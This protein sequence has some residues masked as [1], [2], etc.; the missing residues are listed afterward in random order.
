MKAKRIAL[1]TGIA[2]VLLLLL[3]I[4]LFNNLIVFNLISCRPPLVI[5]K[6]DI[7]HPGLL[8]DPVITEV[9]YVQSVGVISEPD[10][11]IFEQGMWD[12]PVA[13]RNLDVVCGINKEDA[14]RAEGMKLYLF[15]HEADYILNINDAVLTLSSEVHA[16]HEY[17]EF[18]SRFPDDMQAG[19]Y[20]FV[21]V[22]S[23]K[24]IDSAFEYEIVDK[25][26]KSECLTISAYKPVIY[27]YPEE[28]T[29]CLVSLDLDG[30]ITCSYPHYDEDYGWSVTAEPD[31]TLTDTATGREYDY[32]FWEGEISGFDGFDNAIC[33]RGCDTARFLEEY[34]DA[35]GL[36]YSEIDDFIS[37]WLPRMESNEYNLISFP[38]QEYE[39]EVT[40]NVS[41]EPDNVIRVYMVYT[42]LDE[43]VE[44]PEENQLQWPTGADRTGFTVVEWG[45]SVV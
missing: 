31:G 11:E 40:L 28:T 34:L 1:I 39:E 32:L 25:D 19:T 44:I 9:E 13:S 38:T 16:E 30:T 23:D 35:C 5:E 8:C 10:A 7:Y 27:L 36:T 33:I 41:P 26:S 24:R 45:G 43:E 3:Y 37:F 6:G 15:K 14:D 42:P 20:T 17:M 18:F 2:I 4:V 22:D 29:D 12:P 21:F